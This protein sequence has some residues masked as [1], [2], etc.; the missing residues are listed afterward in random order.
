MEAMPDNP[1]SQSNEIWK[2]D[3]LLLKTYILADKLCMERLT[4]ALMDTFRLTRKNWIAALDFLPILSR[5]DAGCESI[6]SYLLK[7][8]AFNILNSGWNGFMQSLQQKGRIRS[9]FCEGWRGCA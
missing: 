1:D 7:Q 6:R 4:N 2:G 3:K 8:L 9:I 5:H